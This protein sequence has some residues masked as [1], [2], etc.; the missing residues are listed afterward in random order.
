LERQGLEINQKT[1]YNLQRKSQS[2]QI[3]DQEEMRL[4]LQDLLN[5]GHHVVVGEV[6][7]LDN[8][9][10]KKERHLYSLAWFSQEQ[11]RLSRRFISGCLLESDDTFNT[12]SK[13][14]LLQNVIGVDNTGKTF[15]AMQLL[16]TKESARLFQLIVKIWQTYYFYDCPGPGVW[17]ADF[18][19]GVT[20]CVA[21][22]AV[23]QKAAAE[24]AA[25]KP[26]SKGKEIAFDIPDLSLL[27]QY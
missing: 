23:A 19:A 10:E 11:I 7:V 4:I 17:C 13:R 24:A 15:P 3:S 2:G 12:N 27:L 1:Y 26:N 18:C 21:Q 20:A 25:A 22:E 9:G 14:L 8:N 6:Y 16:H 5:A